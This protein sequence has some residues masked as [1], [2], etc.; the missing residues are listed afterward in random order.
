MAVEYWM[1]SLSQNS[2]ELIRNLIFC[3][4]T[5]RIL[6]PRKKFAN[7]EVSFKCG[8]SHRTKFKDM[9]ISNVFHGVKWWIIH[10]YAQKCHQICSVCGHDNN[11]EEP[12]ESQDDPNRWAL[13][14]KVATWRK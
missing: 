13:G 2:L 5:I 7:L 14:I 11:T 8:I 10:F 3:M 4:E 12:P 1:W 6:D 9:L